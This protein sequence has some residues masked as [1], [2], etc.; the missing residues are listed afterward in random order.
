MKGIV[1]NSDSHNSR[2]IHTFGDLYR[3]NVLTDVT[4]VCDDRYRVEAHRIVL[5][6][7]SSLFRDFITMNSQSHPLIYLKGVRRH[8]LVSIMQYLYEGEANVKQEEVP[9]LL[10]VAKDLEIAGLQDIDEIGDPRINNP[11]SV[12]DKRKK[13][14]DMELNCDEVFD[15]D[16]FEYIGKPKKQLDED[17]KTLDSISDRNDSK[18]DEI[19]SFQTKDSYTKDVELQNID[20][21]EFGLEFPK[22]IAVSEVHKEFTQTSSVIK[23]GNN[24]KIK[25]TSACRHCSTIH[26]DKQASHLKGH[27]K[28]KHPEVFAA[29]K[30]AEEQ[31]KRMRMEDYALKNELSSVQKLIQSAKT[32]PPGTV[33]IT[34]LFYKEAELR[35]RMMER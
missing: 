15:C 35:R 29:V 6:A 13:E 22:K 31:I 20:I 10:Q 9:A 16:N 33:N 2:L 27:L 3:N 19:H 25:W 7:S 8:D 30:S 26:Y 4:L 24:K 18:E 34:E 32:Q 12:S 28:E 5:C 17:V 14:I 11:T 23:V 1:L 21:S